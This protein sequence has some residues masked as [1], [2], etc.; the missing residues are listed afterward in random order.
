MATNWRSSAAECILGAGLTCALASR[1]TIR[2]HQKS[3]CTFLTFPANA[4]RVLVFI[5]S[6]SESALRIYADSDTCMCIQSSIAWPASVF[7]RALQ[8]TKFFSPSQASKQDC[9]LE[10]SFDSCIS[11]RRYLLSLY[12]HLKFPGIE[13]LCGAQPQCAEMSSKFSINQPLLLARCVA[14]FL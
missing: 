4:V 8:S 14:E 3:L 7:I 12:L 13:R 1:F 10:R 5:R 2:P 9:K 11:V 6:Q